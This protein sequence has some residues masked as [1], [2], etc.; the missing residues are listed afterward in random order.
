VSNVWSKRLLGADVPSG[1][2]ATADVPE[3]KVWVVK[4]ATA[5]TG[6]AGA[7]AIFEGAGFG[8]AA[9][10]TPAVSPAGWGQ[11]LWNGFFVLN[12]GETLE[13]LAEGAAMYLACS[14]YE[15]SA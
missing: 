6:T 8:F 2:S 9:G 1:G 12:A 15:L 3:G 11:F 14:G 4:C 5:V 7:W 10:P 13:A